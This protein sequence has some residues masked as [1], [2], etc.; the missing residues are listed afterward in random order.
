MI[1]AHA[2]DSPVWTRNADVVVAVYRFSQSWLT[3]TT[4]LPLAKGFQINRN[5]NNPQTLHADEDGRL[6]VRLR[7][8]PQTGAPEQGA[9]LVIMTEQNSALDDKAPTAIY[10]FLYQQPTRTGVNSR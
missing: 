10:R 3:G 4:T 9:Y 1:L 2:K 8:D 6:V 7:P 5:S